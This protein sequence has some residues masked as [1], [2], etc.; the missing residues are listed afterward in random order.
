MLQAHI[1]S[2]EE[3]FKTLQAHIQGSV[4]P[5]FRQRETREMLTQTGA[6]L[7]LPRIGVRLMNNFM[8]NR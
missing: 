7:Q 6:N 2:V 8:G 5:L 3:V 4:P 1:Q